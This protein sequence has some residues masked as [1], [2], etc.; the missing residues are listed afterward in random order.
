MEEL[1]D[2]GMGHI[3]NNSSGP[4]T[5]KQSDVPYVIQVSGNHGS[6]LFSIKPNGEFVPGPG[7][8]ES[9]SLTEFSK[10]IYKSMT[11]FGDSFSQT[12]EKKNQRIKELEEEIFRMRSI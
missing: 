11:V 9:T 4:L 6:P 5:I 7:I 2:I 10:F 1:E 3:F 8:T 12:L